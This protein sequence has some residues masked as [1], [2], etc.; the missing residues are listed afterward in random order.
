M[1]KSIRQDPHQT[2][3][4]SHAATA[5]E[6]ALILRCAYV[7]FKVTKVHSYHLALLKLHLHS[8]DLHIAGDVLCIMR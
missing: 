8:T 6:S 1:A 5:D 4:S 7:Y 2:S 3:F